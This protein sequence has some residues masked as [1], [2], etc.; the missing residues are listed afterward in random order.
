MEKQ[1]SATL[2]FSDIA[3][4]GSS[5]K[6]YNINLDRSGDGWSVTAQ[7]GRRGNALATDVKTKNGAV[8]YDAAKKIFDKVVA[9]KVAK[10]YVRGAGES[11]APVAAPEFPATG[12]GVRS[13]ELLT[14]IDERAAAAL[15]LDPDY[16]MQDKSDGH[17]RGVVKAGGVIF[18]LNKLGRKVPLPAEL[19]DELSRINL[20]TFHIDAELVGDKLVCRDLLD[21]DGDIHGLPYEV[22][23]VRLVKA[24]YRES[25]EPREFK[26]ISVVATWEGSFKPAALEQQIKE[27]REGVVFK[28]RGAPH[29]AGRNGQHKKFKFVKTLSAIAGKPRASGKDSV[30]VFLAGRTGV[31]VSVGSV[32]LIGKP[33]VAEGDVV[34]V[35]YLYASAG[36]RLVQPRLMRVRT[37]VEQDECTLDQLIFKRENT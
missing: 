14:E 4:G 23:F 37:D 12:G 30:E 13:Q 11:R 3:Q 5:D 25:A 6:V 20:E 15:V 16:W 17:S 31:V 10:G 2:A 19:H 35:A 1:E 26:H 32:S 28:L 18:G 8:G 36:K 34:E 21:A 9:Q 27:R 7:Y 29:R 22:R 33:P 24:I